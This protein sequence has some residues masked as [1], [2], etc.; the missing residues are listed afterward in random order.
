M[1]KSELSM[2]SA[3]EDLLSNG[4]NNTAKYLIDNQCFFAKVKVMDPRLKQAKEY[5]IID[6]DMPMPDYDDDFLLYS[7]QLFKEFNDVPKWYRS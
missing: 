4:F 1:K 3:L 6:F 2:A 5:T 7:K